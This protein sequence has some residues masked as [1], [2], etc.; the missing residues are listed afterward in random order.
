MGLRGPGARPLRKMEE[1]RRKAEKVL[2]GYRAADAAHAPPV[3]PW[4]APDLSRSERVIVFCE[5]FEIT[6]GPDIGKMF[7]MRPWQRRFI[8][9]VYRD[10][11]GVRPVRTAILSMGRKNGKTALAALLA[12]CHTFGPE[13]EERGEAYSCA[14]DRKQATKIFEEAQASI[15]KHP[16]LKG[17]VN[18]VSH[19]KRMLDM[20]TGS[21]FQALSAEARTKMGLSPS[22]VVYDELGSARD[23][24]LYD[25][26]DSA[27]GARANPLMLVISTQAAD[28]HAPLSTLI[29]H[30]LRVQHGEIDDPSFHLT[31]YQ[32]PVDADIESEA[33]WLLANP[34]MGDFRSYADVKRQ[35]EQARAMPSQENRFRNLIL[36][37]RVAAEAKLFERE[38]W[39]TCGAQAHIPDG[40]KVFGA[41][42]LGATRDMTALVLVWADADDV[43]HVQPHFW[44]PG[45]IIE[46]SHEDMAPYDVWVRNGLL[47]PAGEGTDPKMVAHKIAELNGRYRITSIAF[48]A[49]RITEL[50]RALDEIGC[51]VLL[52]PHGQGFKDMNGAIDVLERLIFQQRIRHGG[53]QILAWNVANAVATRNADG[54][55]KLDKVK[56]SGRIDGVQALAMAF[57]LA[58]IKNVK[59]IDIEALIG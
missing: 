31:L 46:R 18:I 9:D 20:V 2:A 45:N 57:S 41:V 16:Q 17:R 23:R 11:N 49:W 59:P 32:A 42:D 6:S 35:A 51:R 50:Q 47:Y 40:A 4:L 7:K 52:T 19:E 25:A 26:M 22:F 12:L 38:R 30:G 43:F 33:T 13:S 3:A 24:K 54:F 8:E 58:L 29:D 44:L 53:N 36:N 10:E 55:R 28:D 56:S 1:K 21:T 14:N 34:A 27:Q 15:L 48:D 39:K 5:S 37:Q